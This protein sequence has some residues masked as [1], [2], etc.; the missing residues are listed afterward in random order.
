MT[1]LPVTSEPYQQMTVDL[2]GQLVG[3]TL[4]YGTLTDAWAMDLAR[5]GADILR[6]QRLVLGTDLLRAHH[7]GLGALFAFAARDP[8][9]DPG[10][11]DL[12]DRVLLVHMTEAEVAEAISA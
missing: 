10:R 1:I 6:G 2:D 11:G 9:V 8:G 5:E 3:L 7:F 4:R 12:G